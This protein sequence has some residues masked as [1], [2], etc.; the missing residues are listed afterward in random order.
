MS[1]I[2]A[3]HP[4]FPRAGACLAAALAA[5]LGAASPISRAGAQELTR[6]TAA[7]DAGAPS[8]DAAPLAALGLDLATIEQVDDAALLW[9]AVR[10]L[11]LPGKVSVAT[12]RR[13]LRRAWVADPDTRHGSYLDS[14]AH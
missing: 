5:A 6:T 2:L 4:V 14:P 11:V 1:P 7:A 12:Q 8:A 9:R 3:A 10:E 13:L